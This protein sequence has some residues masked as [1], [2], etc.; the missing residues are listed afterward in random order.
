MIGKIAIGILI[1]VA[2]VAQ[3]QDQ[4]APK[5]AEAS[6]LPLS[7][8]TRAALIAE[9]LGV[10]AGVAELSGSIAM[11]EWEAAAQQA[12][13]I[14]DSYIMKQKLSS[15]ELEELEHALPADFIEKDSAFHRHADG[16]AHAARAHDYELEV[17]YFSRMMEG[18]GTCHARYAPNVFKG[19]K[20]TDRTDTH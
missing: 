1:A 20:P 7:A 16:L 17:F 2:S 18:C 15:E 13:R 11:G 19:F 6:V 9:M 5:A 4:V 14:R 10:K 12:E 8:K 3:A